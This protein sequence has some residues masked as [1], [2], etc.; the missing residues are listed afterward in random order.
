MLVEGKVKDYVYAVPGNVAKAKYFSFWD[1][2]LGLGCLNGLIKLS[3]FSWVL[4]L[5]RGC[6]LGENSLFA[7]IRNFLDWL[8]GFSG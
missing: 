3:D 5:P 8:D 7:C 6:N 1:L 4:N 2:G